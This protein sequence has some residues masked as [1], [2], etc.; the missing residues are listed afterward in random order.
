VKRIWATPGLDDLPV[1]EWKRLLAHLAE[2]RFEGIEPLI[3]GPYATPVATILELLGESGLALTGLRTGAI[4]AVHGVTLGHPDPSL[5]SQAVAR[6]NEVIRYGAQ[7]G[8]PRLLVGLLQGPLEPGQTVEETAER[9]V[10]SLRLCA[11]EAA[12]Y[13]MEVDL[14]PVNRYELTYHNRVRQV[15]EVIR[16]ID[17][18]N[19]GILLDTFHMNI[20]EASISAA[21][22][23]AA[24]FLGHLH[25]ADSNRLAPGKGHFDFSDFFAVLE[26]VE[27]QGEVTVETPMPD[28]YEAISTSARSLDCLL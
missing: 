28:Q 11:D 24:P 16:C 13:G 4:A 10:H 27:Y 18:P 5:R 6:L 3:A 26:A 17:R 9:V 25:I 19:V 21:V 7:F 20:E 23:A 22:V 15:I 2:C 8:R 14:E 12:T 1:A